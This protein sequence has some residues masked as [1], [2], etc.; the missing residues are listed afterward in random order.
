MLMQEGLRGRYLKRCEME[1]FGI[2]LEAVVAASSLA[3]LM[4]PSEDISEPG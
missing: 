1:A 2:E 4:S 3:F